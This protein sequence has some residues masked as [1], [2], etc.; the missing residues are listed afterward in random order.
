MIRLA[1][2]AFWLCAGPALALEIAL[3]VTARQTAERNT[4]P[5]IFSAPVGVFENGKVP[6]ITVE[7][8]VE[9]A[10]W[11]IDSPG[12]TPFQVIR[13]LRAQLVEA[14]YT[15]ALDCDASICGGFDFRFAVETLPGPNMYVNIRAYHMVTG[16]RGT[17]E[18]INLLASTSATSAYVQIIQA[19]A[20]GDVATSVRT[21]APVPVNTNTLASGDL[22][23]QLLS[24]GHAVL[25]GLEFSSGSTELGP[26]PFA[27]LAELA[28][29]LQADSSRRVAL[30]G[31][32]DTVGGLQPN[33]TIS[34]ARARSVRQRLIAEFGIA[35]DRLDAEGMGYL[36]PIATNLNPEG[37]DL[38]RRV[39]VILLSASVE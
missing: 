9:R 16:T 7:G 11:R 21:A 24:S 6:R 23:A 15:I 32:T 38:N 31:H 26:G 8:D 1:A 22:S 12:L 35:A 13:P 4:S 19:G 36:S 17:Q 30:V 29:F 28:Q 20:L 10:A 18:V 33:I 37:R 27:A 39:E 3:P 2:F 25:P 34:R 14:G 5:D